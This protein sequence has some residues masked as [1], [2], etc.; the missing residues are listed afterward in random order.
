VQKFYSLASK[1]EHLFIFSLEETIFIWSKTT[2]S[3]YSFSGFYGAL[4]FFAEED[5]DFSHIMEYINACG[6]EFNSELKLV[7]SN[8]VN[9]VTDNEINTDEQ[10]YVT[11]KIPSIQTDISPE[12]IYYI[13]DTYFSLVIDKELEKY[14]LDS[15]K[16]TQSFNNKENLK[17]HFE[18]LKNSEYYEIGIN[19][20]NIEKIRDKEKI[21]PILQDLIRITIYENSDFKV[22]MHSGVLEYD[23]KT[24]ILP[25]VSGSGKSTLSSYLMYNDFH[26]YSDEV[27]SIDS[28]NSIHSLQLCNTIKEG[29]WEIIDTFSDALDN[30]FIHKRFDNQRI[31]F[32]PPTGN[33]TKSINAVGAFMIF[34]TFKKDSKTILNSVTLVEAIS[35]LVESGYHLKNPED[36]EN[37][38]FFLEFLSSCYIYKL[39]YSNLEEAKNKIEEVMKK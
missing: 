3:L 21:L 13:Y 9:L 8:I 5:S 18:V 25:G 2:S 15:F 33:A 19:G 30:L 38:K 1:K 11:Q 39:I 34:P 17:Y 36:L 4:F 22:A 16:H 26:L 10:K 35:L 14:I 37:V 28:K 20:K 31:K 27:T 29:S 23:N 12:N 32:L 24:L 7:V 6:Y